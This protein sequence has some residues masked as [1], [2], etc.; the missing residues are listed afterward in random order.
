MDY[1]P[2]YAKSTNF[3]IVWKGIDDYRSEIE[4]LA[5]AYK[6]GTLSLVCG[7]GVSQSAGIPG[8]NDL[9]AQT[10]KIVIEKFPD[11]LSDHFSSISM[12]DFIE[13]SGL[14]TIIIGR[15]L[16]EKLGDEFIKSIKRVLYN[17]NPSS[18]NLIS[19]IGDLASPQR[20]TS[21][22]NSI[23][24]YNFDDLLEQEFM[25]RNIKFKIVVHES[26]RAKKKEIPIFHV[27]G[28]LPRD[29]KVKLPED[30]ILSED[31]Y[32]KQ[33]IDSFSW[34]N[35]VQIN[36]FSQNTCLFIGISLS[37]PNMR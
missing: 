21:H 17:Q 24:T 27:H 22:L 3:P 9:L 12:P 19:A 34:S 7:A 31:A 29:E 2:R 10:L 32:H 35:L 26:D 5:H 37:D 18:S 8:W 28:F 25:K 23:I 4:S 13:Q 1:S 15:I 11:K 30:I 16:K 33:I 36:E 6:E 14:S 20:D